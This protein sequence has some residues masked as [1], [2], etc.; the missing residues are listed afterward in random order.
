MLGVEN[1]KRSEENTLT[2]TT[3][4]IAIKILSRREPGIGSIVR[5]MLRISRLSSGIIKGL[6]NGIESIIPNTIGNTGNSIQKRMLST[7]ITVELVSSKQE[8]HLPQKSG[9]GFVLTMIIPVSVV[10]DASLK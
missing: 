6:M 7:S 10:G 9:E 3:G 5:K 8:G 1:T 2:N 4:S